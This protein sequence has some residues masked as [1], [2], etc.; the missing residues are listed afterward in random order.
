MHIA[1]AQPDVSQSWAA[2]CWSGIWNPKMLKYLY[3][4]HDGR[5]SIVLLEKLVLAK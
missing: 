4:E 1:I 2:P 3:S 5:A